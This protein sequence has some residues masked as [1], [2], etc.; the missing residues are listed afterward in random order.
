[1]RLFNPGQVSA[2]VLIGTEALGLWARRNWWPFLSFHS[3]KQLTK[4]RKS[5]K[6]KENQAHTSLSFFFNLYL[7]ITASLMDVSGSSR[8]AA[9]AERCPPKTTA[10]ALD[11]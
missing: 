3:Y 2:T 9:R 11:G 1:L 10:A 6:K 5:S 7:F 4:E 8:K